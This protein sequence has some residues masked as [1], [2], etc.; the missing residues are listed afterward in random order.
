MALWSGQL[1]QDLHCLGTQDSRRELSLTWH[2]EG[3]SALQG[4]FCLCPVPSPE[5]SALWGPCPTHSTCPR[6][7]HLPCGHRCSP[8]S[9]PQLGRGRGV[10]GTA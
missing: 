9:V 2:K 7:Q 4:C 5:P 3:R 10:Q 8:P 6:H 1:G